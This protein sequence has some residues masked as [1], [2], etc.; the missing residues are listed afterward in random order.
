MQQL[1]LKKQDPKVELQRLMSKM[2]IEE[3]Q[4]QKTLY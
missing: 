3:I 4:A 2:N 1:N